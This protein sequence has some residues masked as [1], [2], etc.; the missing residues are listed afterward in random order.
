MNEHRPLLSDNP[1]TETQLALV[2]QRL[3]DFMVNDRDWKQ[4]FDAK[5][6][7]AL[8]LRSDVER[9]LRWQ[10]QHDIH[11]GTDDEAIAHRIGPG[12]GWKVIAGAVA[13]GAGMASIVGVVVQ[14]TLRVS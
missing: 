14:I 3:S 7:A 5:V 12:L 4:R 6:D 11:H 10:E 8:H 13:L 9:A 1:S 2:V